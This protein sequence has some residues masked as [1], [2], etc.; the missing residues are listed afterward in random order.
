[1]LADEY[2]EANP[3][4]QRVPIYFS[5][6][7]AQQSLEVFQVP[8]Q[9]SLVVIVLVVAASPHRRAMP[10]TISFADLPQLDE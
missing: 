9:P 4:L 2:W 3:H 10:P 1:M 8:P 7:L 6:K 5:S